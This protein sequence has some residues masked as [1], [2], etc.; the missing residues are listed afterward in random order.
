MTEHHCR[1]KEVAA[2]SIGLAA[3]NMDSHNCQ[4]I[5]KN[6]HA[7][8]EGDV[9]VPP[10]KPYPISY[11]AIVPKAGQCGNLLVPVCLSATHIAYGSIRMEPVFMILGQSAATAACLA[12]E[13]DVPVQRVNYDR[14]RTRL[15]ADK[16]ILEWK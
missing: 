2:D 9:Q 6:G 14:L 11:R 10:M 8:N 5:V 13:E 16:Q 7:E 3:Y 12:I 15:L 1:G 4:R